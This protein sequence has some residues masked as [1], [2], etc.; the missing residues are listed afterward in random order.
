MVL[1][2]FATS[3]KAQQQPK[4]IKR[5]NATTNTNKSQVSRSADS[6]RMVS[7]AVDS[8]KRSN[9]YTP[10]RPYEAIE[11]TASTAA[12]PIDT[13]TTNRN[14]TQPL[15]PAGNNSTGIYGGSVNNNAQMNGQLSNQR[16]PQS[17][18]NERNRADINQRPINENSKNAISDASSSQVNVLN[19]NQMAPPPQNW[20]NT[21]QGQNTW[22]R[23][24]LG[25]AQWKPLPSVSSGFAR[26]FPGVN[27]AEWRRDAADTLNYAARFRTGNNWAITTYNP[28]GTRLE[29]RTEFTVSELPRPVALFRDKQ[30]KN[31]LDIKQVSRIDRPSRPSL[32]AVHLGTGRIVYVNE[33]GLTEEYK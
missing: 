22:G 29:T 30:G 21:A 19:Q 7:S 8:F 23:N 9:R 5:I 13:T 1:G 3:S 16:V 32:Y 6:G 11:G 26:D 33:Q 17:P 12:S 20:G 25:E 24:T 4:K 15:H 18:S 27:G 2:L 10:G 31:T 28:S 14:P